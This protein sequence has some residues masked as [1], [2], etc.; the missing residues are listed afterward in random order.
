M[1]FMVGGC[2]VIVR[3]FEPEEVLRTIER[4]RITSIT[5]VPT[6]MARWWRSAPRCCASTTPRRCAGSC[7]ARR[8]CR[9]E[10]ARRVEDAFGP[11]LYNFY[12][13]T[14]TGP[15]HHRAAGRAH[16]AAG[17]HR[18]AHRRQRGAPA[19][20]RRATRCPTARS[21]SSTCATRM[22]MDGYHGN[23]KATDDATRDGFISVGDLAYRDADGYLLPRRPQD[24]HGDLGR[25]EHLPVGDRAAAARAPG[26]ARGGG[27]RRARRGVGRVA[28]GVHRA[29]RGADGD[30]ARSSSQWVK[31]TLADYKRPRSVAFVD[32][33]PRTPTGKVLKRELKAAA[34]GVAAGERVRRAAGAGVRRRCVAVVA[35][36]PGRRAPTRS[37]ASATARPSTWRRGRWRS[38]ARCSG[39]ASTSCRRCSG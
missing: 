35:A 15:R 29:A 2:S 7:R 14:E 5:V 19:R 30:A 21:A 9:R 16:R 6:M 23:E 20:R 1:I 12:G 34:G 17:H 22:L 3:H 25:R 24:G 10:L 32:A 39:S 33:L 8:R 36:A 26:G 13:A 18:P 38:S 27:G 28:G 37:I 31:E 11:I 4:E